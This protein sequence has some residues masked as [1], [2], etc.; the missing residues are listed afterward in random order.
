M[1]C[2]TLPREGLKP[3]GVEKH[4]ERLAAELSA[5]GHEVTVYTYT[6]G[7]SRKGFHRHYLGREG[8]GSRPLARM[9]LAPLQL[10]N[11]DTAVLDV[12]HLH[13]DDWFFLRRRVPT[14]RT[15]YGSALQEARTATRLRRKVRMYASFPLEVLA[16]RLATHSY[17]LIPGADRA[18]VPSGTLPLATSGGVAVHDPIPTSEPTVL[19]VGTWGGRKRGAML[20]DVFRRE[21][22]SVL[23]EA[24]LLLVSDEGV[25]GDGVEWLGSPSDVELTNLYRQ[26]WAFCLPS[27]YEGYGMPYVE[28]MSHGLPVIATPNPGAAFILNAGSAG[29]LVDE[30]NLG[31]AIVRLLTDEELRADMSARALARA[32]EITSRDLVKEH[33]DAYAKAVDRYNRRTTR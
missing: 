3:G 24:R 23:P 33:V 10:H 28:A 25:S 4:V 17:G 30:V 15:F 7:D 9:L 1:F 18:Y 6:R 31:A 27:S 19:F 29:V 16:S 5:A 21:V 26:A 22:R 13:G 20:A 14:V 8:I 11:V 12:L 32:F 2:A